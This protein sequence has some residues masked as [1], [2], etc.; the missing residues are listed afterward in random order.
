MRILAAIAWVVLIGSFVWM[1]IASVVL[2][3]EEKDSFVSRWFIGGLCLSPLWILCLLLI[4]VT[5]G[6]SRRIR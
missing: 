4:L 3:I 2:A 5:Q 1:N 6:R